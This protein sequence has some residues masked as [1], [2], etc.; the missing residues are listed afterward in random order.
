M[1]IF[2]F[3]ER[4]LYTIRLSDLFTQIIN[5]E[6]GDIVFMSIWDNVSYII[7]FIVW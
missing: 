6:I 2:R 3:I 5:Y 4:L 1:F 7:I